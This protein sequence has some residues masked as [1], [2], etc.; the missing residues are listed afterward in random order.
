[1]YDLMSIQVNAP[2]YT[3]Q[4]SM[5]GLRSSVNGSSVNCGFFEFTLQA[6]HRDKRPQS[7]PCR[8]SDQSL[9]TQ[10][11]KSPPFKSIMIEEKHHKKSKRK[12]SAGTLVDRFLL[13]VSLPCPSLCDV[14]DIMPDLTNRLIR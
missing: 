4:M 11:I 7:G 3:N 10:T 13:R 12:K 2:P 1:M 8:A 6:G 5:R 14:R 9:D